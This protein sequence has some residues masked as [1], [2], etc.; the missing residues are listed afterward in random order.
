[1]LPDT[2]KMLIPI[3]KIQY[4]T[5]YQLYGSG[6]DTNGSSYNIHVRVTISIVLGTIQMVIRILVVNL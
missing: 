2:I 5:V 4:C 6:H 1:M 3:Q